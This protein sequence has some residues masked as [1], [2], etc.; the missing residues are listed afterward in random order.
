MS[1]NTESLPE[2]GSKWKLET[3]AELYVL[4]VNRKGRGYTVVWTAEGACGEGIAGTNALR[5]FRSKAKA[6]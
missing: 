4:A 1:E 5:E 6:A 3:G 2:V